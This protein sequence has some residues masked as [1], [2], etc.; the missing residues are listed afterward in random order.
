MKRATDG[1]QDRGEATRRK[2]LVAAIEAFG[3]FG[4]EGVS[5][6]AIAD[7]AGV[8]LQAITYYFGDKEK[9]YLA[10]AGHITELVK[11]HVADLSAGL[12]ERLD[13]ADRGDVPIDKEEARTRL[14]DITRT[15]ATLFVNRDSD[16]WARFVIHEQANPTGAFGILYGGVMRPMLEV[17]ERLLAVVLDEPVGTE[18]LRLRLMSLVG[19]ILVFRTGRAGLLALLG[20]SEVG[21][22]E[23]DLILDLVPELLATIDRRDTTHGRQ[24]AFDP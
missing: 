22:R 15:M 17:A 9:L 20:W 2:L 23:A 11:A 7:A 5:T 1:R 18:H 13:A 4:F 3:R 8:N 24:T 21:K 19:S 14:T 12:N 6:R 16:L 10:A